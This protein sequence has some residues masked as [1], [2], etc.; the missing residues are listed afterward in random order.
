[1]PIDF[2]AD[3]EGQAPQKPGILKQ[4]AG[5][6]PVQAVKGATKGAASVGGILDLLGLQPSQHISTPGE[7]ARIKMETEANPHELAALGA[8]ASDV[9]PQFTRAANPQDVEEML[10]EAKTTVGRF[11][12]R[13]AEFATAA[14]GLG[15]FGAR[16][17]GA[18]VLASTV[19]QTL[20]EAGAPPWAQA[21]G[22]II[23]AIKSG[24]VPRSDFTNPKN[25]RYIN[26]LKNDLGFSDQDVTLAVNALKNKGFLSKTGIFTGDAA[27]RFNESASNFGKLIKTQIGKTLTGFKEG[28][29]TLKTKAATLFDE[30]EG[31]ASTVHIH[32]PRT[33]QREG[34]KVLDYLEK[35]LANSPDTK[36]VITMLKE[37]LAKT[38]LKTHAPEGI[39]RFKAPHLPKNTAPM[40]AGQIVDVTGKHPQTVLPATGDYYTEFYRTLNDVGDWISPGKREV[41]FSKMKDA[42]KA[43]FKNQGKNGQRLAK[44]LETFN[45]KWQEMIHTE[46]LE[47]LFSKVSDE[48]GLNFPKLTT[49]LQNPNT[50][51]TVVDAVGK[52]SANNIRR[53][54]HAGKNIKNLEKAIEGGQAKTLFTFAK[55]TKFLTDLFKGNVKGMALAVG[56]EVSQRIATRML[57]DPKFQNLTLKLMHSAKHGAINSRTPAIVALNR[58]IESEQKKAYEELDFVP[59]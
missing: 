32:N 18:S 54:A 45:S 44:E 31:L 49:S 33:F 37:A 26:S 16:E 35:N 23:T 41:V 29:E 25:S 28:S 13:G 19:G 52:T 2:I 36:K 40:K 42:I 6:I 34:Q 20:E 3:E 57:T 53:I 56:T 43:T 22:E 39:T 21:A 47:K 4:I 59:D 51:K 12:K 24:Q 17:A 48:K 15:P 30:M 58:E 10:P 46:K 50:Y 38:P 55:G 9:M 5:D 27:R 1:M 8:D 14:A 7:K 11:V